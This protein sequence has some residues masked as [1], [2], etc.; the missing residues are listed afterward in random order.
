MK[1][2]RNQF[3][4]NP[5]DSGNKEHFKKPSL[6]VP[7]MSMTI[8]ELVTRYTRGQNIKVLSPSW[9]ESEDKIPEFDGHIDKLDKF[10]KMDLA[11]KTAEEIK[12][13]TE[14]IKKRRKSAKIK[15]DEKAKKEAEQKQEQVP[16]PSPPPNITDEGKK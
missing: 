15:A 3:N 9:Y 4:Y 5:N 12:T 7:D 1:K 11:K 8:T 10:E 6:T 14:S 16:P 2:V 13:T